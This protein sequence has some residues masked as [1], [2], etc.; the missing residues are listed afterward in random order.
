MAYVD[1]DAQ[2]SQVPPQDQDLQTPISPLYCW[3]TGEKCLMS[4]V[5]IRDRIQIHSQ[6]EKKRDI[7][8]P[9]GEPSTVREPSRNSKMLTKCL[10][11]QLKGIKFWLSICAQAQTLSAGCCSHQQRCCHLYLNLTGT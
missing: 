3:K 10:S 5:S 9:K 7:C 2:L 8:C 6:P 1:T 4:M 11:K